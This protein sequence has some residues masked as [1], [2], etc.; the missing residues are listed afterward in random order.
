M[1][2][3]ENRKCEVVV[4]TMC[5]SFWL[6]SDPWANRAVTRSFAIV[7]PLH[8]ERSSSEPFPPPRE[9]KNIT[10]NQK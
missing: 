4:L 9:L 3:I 5:L 7:P 6:P 8:V 10:N 1:K 2:I